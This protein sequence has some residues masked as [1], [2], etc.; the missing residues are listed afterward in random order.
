MEGGG[1]R[2]CVRHLSAWHRQAYPRLEAAV[3]VL[4]IWR[5]PQCDWIEW[6]GGF[7]LFTRHVRGHLL[8]I[9][10]TTAHGL[11]VCSGAAWKRVASPLHT[12]TTLV[13]HP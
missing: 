13:Q 1:G 6:N 10:E 3:V 12:R 8:R 9:G 4:E 11:S 5:L 7:K 2:G